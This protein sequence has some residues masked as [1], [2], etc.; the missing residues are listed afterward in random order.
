MGLYT[1]TGVHKQHTSGPQWDSTQTQGYTNNTHQARNGTLHRHSGK[2]IAHI[3]PAMR[4]R[5]IHCAAHTGRD[6]FCFHYLRPG[7]SGHRTAPYNDPQR[8]AQISTLQNYLLAFLLK[9]ITPPSTFRFRNIT[10]RPNVQQ[11]CW[12][13]KSLPDFATDNEAFS[14]SHKSPNSQHCTVHLSDTSC[15]FKR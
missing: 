11:S 8:P 15:P 10:F 14:E 5:V 9:T 12:I 6:C 2:Q 3:R 4:H 7:S 13:S 1:D